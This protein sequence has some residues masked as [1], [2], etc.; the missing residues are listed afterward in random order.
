MTDTNAG[1]AGRCSASSAASLPGSRLKH[2]AR[3]SAVP[4]GPHP[5]CNVVYRLA[6]T[7]GRTITQR[8]SRR[9]AVVDHLASWRGLRILSQQPDGTRCWVWFVILSAVP[10]ASVREFATECPHYSERSF[11]AVGVAAGLG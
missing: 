4:S 2:R 11:K 7:E 9:E 6:F 10:E 5:R 1:G 8:N 3:S